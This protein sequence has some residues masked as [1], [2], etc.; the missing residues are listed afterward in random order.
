MGLLLAWINY[1]VLIFEREELRNVR[2]NHIHKVPTKLSY[3][4]GRISQQL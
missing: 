2:V 4:T 3:S 1:A